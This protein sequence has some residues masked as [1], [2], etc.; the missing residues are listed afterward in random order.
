MN[1]TQYELAKKY[2]IPQAYV[3][4]CLSRSNVLP[5]GF[6][7]KEGHSRPFKAYDENK[8]IEAFKTYFREKA[9]EMRKKARELDDKAESFRTIYE[10]VYLVEHLEKNS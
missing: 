9:E 8:A 4:I 10:K 6:M 7:R 3:S 1:L 2:D 5:A